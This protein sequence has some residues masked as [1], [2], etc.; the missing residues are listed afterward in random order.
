MSKYKFS[1][2]ERRVIY[3]G[4]G[5]KCFY[6]GKPI[7][8]N[9]FHID[10]IIPENKINEEE[11][12]KEKLGLWEEFKINSYYNWVPSYPYENSRKGK[13]EYTYKT[14]LHYLNIIKHKVP[15]LLKLEEKYKKERDKDEILSDLG[16]KLELG[17]IKRK[18][19]IEYLD[20][21][22]KF[23]FS[24][25]QEDL[26]YFLKK[27]L[28]LDFRYY[29]TGPALLTRTGYQVEHEVF[30]FFK[31]HYN[32]KLEPMGFEYDIRF[33]TKD[34]IM[35]VMI[36]LVKTNIRPAIKDELLKGFLNH[37]EISKLIL[38]I[39]CYSEPIK[40]KPNIFGNNIDFSVEKFKDDDLKSNPNIVK[41]LIKFKE[42]KKTIIVVWKKLL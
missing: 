16:I 20:T 25:S 19:I 33:E 40:I 28:L 24:K 23:S 9:N 34:E 13:I 8:I 26:E 4:H 32:T 39:F 30:K 35:G 7:L 5:P 41:Y 36:K 10:H 2:I 12:I 27:F 3:E 29:V 21:L 31:K 37:E 11:E 42:I 15:K 6:S 38:I 1:L 18:E 14:I 22:V 17:I